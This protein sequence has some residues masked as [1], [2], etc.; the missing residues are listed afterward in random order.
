[1]LREP[2]TSNFMSTGTEIM[3]KEAVVLGRSK[4]VVSS[5]AFFHHTCINVLLLHKWQFGNLS[6]VMLRHIKTVLSS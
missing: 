2:K 3:G 5:L 6:M 1:M 4:I